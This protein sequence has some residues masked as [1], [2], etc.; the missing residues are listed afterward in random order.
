LNPWAFDGKDLFGMEHLQH[1][2]P[3]S[4]LVNWLFMLLAL[5][6]ERLYR[7]RYLH[8][9]THPVP[10][11]MQLKDALWPDLRPAHPNSS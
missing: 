10:T 2:H 3:N 1:H 6:I 9:G 11:S 4:M 8:R 5:M 7:T